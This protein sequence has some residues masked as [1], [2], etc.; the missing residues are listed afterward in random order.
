MAKAAPQQ[1]DTSKYT[2][3]QFQAI[4]DQCEGCGRIVEAGADKFCRTYA[5]PAAKWRQGLC[6][7]ATHAKPEIVAAAVK[8]N[9][10]KASKRAAAK[11]KK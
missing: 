3:G 9:P 8:V 10:L 11:K 5:L 6:N 2:S 7:F 4:V 1:E